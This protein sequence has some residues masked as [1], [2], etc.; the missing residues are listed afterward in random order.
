MLFEVLSGFGV[1]AGG[2]LQNLLK[3]GQPP[4]QDRAWDGYEFGG[5]WGNKT[6]NVPQPWC[7]ADYEVTPYIAEFWN[8]LTSLT[9]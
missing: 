7:E 5:Y 2:G 6:N 8:T 4:V 1:I 9:M 3:Q